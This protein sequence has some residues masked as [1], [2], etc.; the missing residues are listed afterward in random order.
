[1]CPWQ[2]NVFFLKKD[3]YKKVLALQI[4]ILETKKKKKKKIWESFLDYTD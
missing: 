2:I 4:V 3:S 1:M